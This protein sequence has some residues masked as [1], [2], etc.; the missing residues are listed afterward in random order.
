LEAKTPQGLGES[1]DMSP[2][3]LN[4][5]DPQLPA[6]KIEHKVIGHSAVF[7]FKNRS[8][9]VVKFAVGVTA[10]SEAP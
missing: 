5:P 10:S 3:L 7:E 1:N 6:S 8:S 2:S 9:H 4:D